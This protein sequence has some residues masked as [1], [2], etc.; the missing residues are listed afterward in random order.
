MGK[1][2]ACPNAD[3]TPVTLI[4]DSTLALCPLCTAT[5]AALI[6]EDETTRCYWTTQRH[7]GTG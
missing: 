7:T 2:Q 6:A 3:A 4:N 5:H 1:C